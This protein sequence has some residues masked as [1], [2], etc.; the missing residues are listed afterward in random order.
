MTL[1]G[2]CVRFLFRLLRMGSFTS[3]PKILNEDRADSD[4][5]IREKV[6]REELMLKCKEELSHLPLQIKRSFHYLQGLPAPE[7]STVDGV[8]PRDPESIRIMQWNVLSQSLGEKNDNFVACPKEALYWKSRRWRMLEEIL[9]YEAD[10]LC[11]QEVDHFNFLKKTLEAIDFA[12]TF[13]PKPDSPCYYIK[14]NNGPDG[15]AIFY[16]TNKF[17]L[18]KTEIRILEICSCQSNQV[19]ILCIFRRKSD[20][21]EFCVATTHLKARQGVLLSSVRNEQGKDL[22]EFIRLHHDQ[23]PVIIT[24]DF[25]AEPSEPVYSTLTTCAELK[26]DSA[27]AYL[28]NQHAEP[29]YTTWKIREE[30]EVCHTLDYIFFSKDTMELQSLLVFPCGEDIGEDRVPSYR[31]SSDHFSLVCDFRF[32]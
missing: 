4:L 5:D 3:T 12:G 27:Y 8:K 22:L 18:L 28:S 24:G 31:Y 29:P 16:D 9:T 11:F 19:M 23:R 32:K 25:N 20:G 6:T 14:G 10:I 15:C 17:D 1:L 26:L 7:E 13:F 2:T 21:Q 30:G